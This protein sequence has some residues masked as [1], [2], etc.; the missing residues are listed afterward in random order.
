MSQLKQARQT[1]SDL[2]VE[3]DAV[4]RDLRRI[5]T[6]AVSANRAM[7][8]A[9]R[10]EFTRA[11]E[12]RTILEGRLAENAV[13]LREAEAANELE[14]NF[15]P[16]AV[17]NSDADASLAA[18]RRAGF[19]MPTDG[20]MRL[21]RP[22]GAKFAQLSPAFAAAAHDAGGFSAGEFLFTLGKGLHHGALRMDSQLENEPSSGGFAVPTQLW[23][24]WLDA[25][26]EDEIVRPR[27]TTWPMQSSTLA[28]PAWDDLDRSSGAIGNIA[29]RFAG[30][31]VAAEKQVAKLRQLVLKARKGL[32]FVEVSN[33]LLSDAPSFDANLSALLVK[34]MSFGF[35]YRFLFGDGATGPLG[36]L[37]S[38]ATITVTR[39]AAGAI[40]Y[41]DLTAMFSR[42]AP[43]SVSRSVWVANPSTIPQ[44]AA[45]SV[46]VGTGGS[47]VPV[48]TQSDGKFLI[49]TREVLFSEK[50]P[51]LGTQS[52]ISLC[53]FSQYAIGVRREAA[54]ERSAHVGFQED[55]STYRLTAR[56]DGQPTLS[57]PITPM[58]GSTLSPFVTLA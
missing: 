28:V 20:A 57:S 49:L 40:L 7:T 36:A 21:L 44:L 25:A 17:P 58:N 35:D 6:A 50:V 52:D 56:I 9:E 5:G 26:L 41:E 4:A 37:V 22:A 10:A 31:T 8:D 38:P 45:L 51:A 13:L 33:E 46:V 32:L 2:R 19:R 54:L 30:E 1:D 12:R 16:G 34:A 3:I 11:S 39:A 48:M 42:L 18:A 29:L 47:H 43:G 27:A 24:Q 55:V 15:A 23:A 14:R 53:D